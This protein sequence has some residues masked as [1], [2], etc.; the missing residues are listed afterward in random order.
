MRD[1]SY[2]RKN[3]TGEITHY[4]GI[5]YDITTIIE[6]QNKLIVEKNK[7]Q[8]YLTIAGVMLIS[9]DTNG[10]VQLINPKGCEILG[11]KEEEILGK[12]Y[13]KLSLG[14]IFS[15]RLVSGISGE[16]ILHS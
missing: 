7:A 4:E 15:H 3:S 12:N 11:Y 13:K 16:R 10:I 8:N 9:I 6:T 2:I 1:V 5:V 14:R